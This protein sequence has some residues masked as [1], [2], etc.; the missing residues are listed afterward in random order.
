MRTSMCQDTPS[1]RP[2]TTTTIPEQMREEGVNNTTISRDRGFGHVGLPKGDNPIANHGLT[3]VPRREGT[4]EFETTMLTERRERIL[5]R[6]KV[7]PRR[8]KIHE[9]FENRAVTHDGR[10]S[11]RAEPI[12][13]P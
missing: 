11:E 7:I 8:S 6:G 1:S 12:V 5:T 13:S 3:V 10:G 9:I 4:D 2:Q